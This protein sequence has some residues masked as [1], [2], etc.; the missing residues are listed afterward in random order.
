[1]TEGRKARLNFQKDQVTIALLV[2]LLQPSKRLT[3]R[4]PRHA[5]IT[6]DRA[7]VVRPADYTYK[8]KGKVVKETGS[9]L[10]VVLQKG[11]AGWRIS[12]WTWAKN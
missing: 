10:T 8:L 7:Y 2:C 3:L 9:I 6:A 5:D 12:A 11:A 4:S 1:M